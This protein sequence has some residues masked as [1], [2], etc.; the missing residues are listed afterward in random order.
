MVYF[1]FCLGLALLVCGGEML[2]K[3]G[4]KLAHKLHISPLLIGIVLMGCG[5]SLPE[6]S[7]SLSS[8]YSTPPMPGLAFGNIIGSNISNILLILGLSAIISPMHIGHAGFRRDGL[9]LIMSVALMGL[10]MM[11]GRTDPVIGVFFI[12]MIFGYFWICYAK[13]PEP[14]NIH[15]DK[16]NEHSILILG[17]L[18][19]GGIAITVYG[20]DLL[21]S[22]ASGIARA[23]G[24]SESVIGLTLVAI[25]TSLPELTVSTVAAIHKHS[26]VAYG[27]I[28]GSNIANILLI[29]G[30][31]GIV[32]PTHVPQMWNTFW[33]MVI[34]T[35]ALLVC[36]WRGRI[37]RWVGVM[38]LCA[39]AI[40]IAYLF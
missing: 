17:G 2:V 4:I 24:V 19:I 20:A 14:E 7:T 3:N 25:G 36:G 32:H 35:A 40:Y 1:M 34:T 16:K 13:E 5:T 6:I 12:L 28:I 18:A 38:F 9:F 10:V 27:N 21:V 31:I 15:I 22:S 30:T 23:F 33:I 39:Y 29:V 11:F 8:L 37:P 26:S